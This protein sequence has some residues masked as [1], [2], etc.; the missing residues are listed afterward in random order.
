MRRGRCYEKVK[1]VTLVI[2]V[3]HMTG[4]HVRVIALIGRKMHAMVGLETM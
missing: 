3:Q 1:I 4:Q 2:K